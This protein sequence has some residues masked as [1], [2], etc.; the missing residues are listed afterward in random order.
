MIYKH[1]FL[2]FIIIIV[3]LGLIFSPIL[4][5]KQA[6]IKTLSPITKNLNSTSQNFRGFFSNIKSIKIL[7]E[8]N[9]EAKTR[10]QELEAE[11]AQLKEIRHE[12]EILKEELGFFQSEKEKSL[13]PAQI[14]SRS[15]SSYLQNITI[16]KGSNDG[17]NQNNLVV[18]QGYLIGIISEVGPEF[19]Q[20]QLIT[21]SKTIIP[22]I[23]QNSRGTGLLKSNLKGLLIEDIPMDAVIKPGEMVLTSGL[24]E[25]MPADFVVGRV[26][27]ITSYQSQIFQTVKVISPIEFSKLEM[28]FVVK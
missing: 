27:T 19:S 20:I 25:T 17:V 28:I 7:S 18:S 11:L 15:V 4:P 10:I 8:E 3:I 26:E 9:K 2:I 24:G 5:V 21:D 13:I 22:V 16:D 14:V 6:I 23:L 12:N 1:R